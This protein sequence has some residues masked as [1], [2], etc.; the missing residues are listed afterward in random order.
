MSDFSHQTIRLSEDVV[1][2]TFPY[3]QGQILEYF[4]TSD[5]GWLCYFLHVLQVNNFLSYKL[6]LKPFSKTLKESFEFVVIKDYFPKDYEGQFDG[7]FE[8]ASEDQAVISFDSWRDPGVTLVVPTPFHNHPNVTRKYAT[9]SPGRRMYQGMEKLE[10][11]FIG[12][13]VRATFLEAYML[14]RAK[15]VGPDERPLEWRWIEIWRVVADGVYK[16]LKSRPK[17]AVSTHGHGVSWLHFRVET[18]PKY[19]EK[20][21]WVKKKK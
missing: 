14:R 3:T 10:M 2:Y 1:K 8:E 4:K 17:V 7:Y 6:E 21:F 18:D 20:N 5:P 12:P 9:G 11:S 13:F 15:N 16:K 19:T